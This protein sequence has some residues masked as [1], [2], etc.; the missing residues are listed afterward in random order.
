MIAL[1]ED[2]IGEQIEFTGPE[3]ANIIAFIHSAEEQKRFTEKDI[4]PRIQEL[5]S[6]MGDET[7]E[8]EDEEHK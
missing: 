8:H 7:E 3:L 1:Q 4:P 5:M 2:E 6:H